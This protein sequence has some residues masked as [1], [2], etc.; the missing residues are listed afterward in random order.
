MNVEAII[1]WLLLIDA[2]GANLVAWSGY[3]EWF[4]KNFKPLSRFFPLTRGW[5]TYYLVL[6]LFSG[7]LLWKF[8]AL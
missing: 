5:T 8:G 7:Y 4:T 3:R 1:F 2:I 6:V